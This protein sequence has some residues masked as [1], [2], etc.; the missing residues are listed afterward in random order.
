[1]VERTL[2]LDIGAE[3]FLSGGCNGRSRGSTLVRN[4][5]ARSWRA[6]FRQW[7]R[8]RMMDNFEGRDLE[9]EGIPLI[10]VLVVANRN[11]I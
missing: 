2:V 9:G 6:K 11:A 4:R 5:W 7:R 8:I 10:T 3:R 1:V